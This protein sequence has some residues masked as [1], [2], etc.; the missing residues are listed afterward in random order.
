M[1]DLLYFDSMI[2]PRI[3]TF[4]YW[5]LLI[6]IVISGLIGVMGAFGTMKY[7]MMSGLGAL[8]LVPLAMIGAVLLARIYCEILIVMFKM[9]EALQELRKK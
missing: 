6:G 5:L 3:I 7:S 9:N 4:V 1:R 8:V 2:T